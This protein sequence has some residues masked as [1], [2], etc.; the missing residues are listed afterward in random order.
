MLR[1][2]ADEVFANVIA[3]LDDIIKPEVTDPYAS[4]IVLTV[5]NLMR[6][7]RVRA[8]QEPEALWYD[9]RDLRGLLA[10]LGVEAPPDPDA[11]QY[12][13]LARLVDEA[14]ALR[15]AL[16]PYVAAHPGDA[17]VRAYLGRQL[18]RQRPWM[19]EAWEGARR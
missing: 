7:L 9:N 19:V 10:E 8:A 15:A 14:L 2:T 6:H 5:S 11:A 13:S 4:S 12:P 1:P 17:R 18:E 3:S 16:D